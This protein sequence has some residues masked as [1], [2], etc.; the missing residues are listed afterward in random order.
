VS[1][2]TKKNAAVGYI[3]L[4]A[5]SRARE[6]RRRKRS[7]LK[8]A[9]YLGLG[10]VSLGVL[11]GFAVVLLRR[12]QGEHE[13][14]EGYAEEDEDESEVVGEYVMATPEPIPAT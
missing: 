10:I 11:A 3:T 5:V 4:K 12:Q 1:I 8:F 2:F 14:L 13:H 9:L 6:R 7:G